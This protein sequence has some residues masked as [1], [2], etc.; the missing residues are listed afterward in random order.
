M[1]GTD[2]PAY[3]EAGKGQAIVFLHGMLGSS[4]YWQELMDTVSTNYHAVALDL[5]G[6]GN[7]PKPKHSNY[8]REDHI[9]YIVQTLDR[10]GVDEPVILV[11]HSMGALIALAL[12]VKYPQRV[13]RLILIS[14]P[15]YEN[16]SQARRRIT[17]N[18]IVPRLMYYGPIARMV[19]ATMC[20]LQ[21]L[22]RVLAPVY[23]K[24]LPK[25]IAAAATMHTWYSYS[26]SMTNVIENQNVLTDLQ[27]IE[28]PVVA[29]FGSH[30]NVASA[31]NLRT[32]R[33]CCMDIKITI[34]NGGH[35]LPLELPTAVVQAIKG[36]AVSSG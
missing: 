27:Q 2:Q 28:V 25:D 8:S 16:A 6:F 32:I 34:V 12:A 13:A 11:G 21:P 7:A 5:L 24:H 1:P 19:C 29:L 31:S 4:I 14:M 36:Q 10:L 26:R 3:R 9:E 17:R 22:A 23:F 18:G 15:V 35:H 30:D 20:K 33:R